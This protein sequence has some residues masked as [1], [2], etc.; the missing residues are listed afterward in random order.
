MCAIPA[1]ARHPSLAAAVAG[2]GNKG[3]G[4]GTREDANDPDPEKAY[5]EA[6]IAK[7][8]AWKGRK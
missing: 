5:E 6:R 8:S 4:A 2:A 3:T 1:D 7:G